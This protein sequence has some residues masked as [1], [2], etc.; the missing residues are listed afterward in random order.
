MA[1]RNPIT[2]EY[3]SFLNGFEEPLKSTYMESP[4]K[5]KALEA[6]KTLS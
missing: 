3:P 4:P 6:T 2:L 1:K 5:I